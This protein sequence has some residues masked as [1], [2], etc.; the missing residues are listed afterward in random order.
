M[1]DLTFDSSFSN[2]TVYI[3]DGLTSS[4]LQTARHLSE[5]LSDLKYEIETPYCSIIRTDSRSSFFTA[6]SEIKSLC[7][8]GIRP[9]IHIECHG[10][11]NSGITIGDKKEK[12]AWDEL[13][14]S[15][16]EV[17]KATK[18]NLGI[19]MAGCFGLHAIKP[20]TITKPSP[21][22]FLIGSEGEISAGE[23]DEAMKSFYRA[24]FQ[25]DS[26]QTAMG[27]ID[28]RFKQFHAE[29][30]F[31]ISFGRYIKQKCIGK[32]RNARVENL[33]SELFENGI[34]RNR[35]SLRRYR[36]ELKQLT[37][38]NK[39]A[40]QKFADIFMHGRYAITYEQLHTFV[41]QKNNPT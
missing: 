38:P 17:N 23:I 35:E 22:Y 7:I 13:V 34:P 2:N 3:L 20:I 39:A 19:V 15:F 9:I 26:L 8:D 5:G 6:L 32:G 1:N 21:F 28:K 10:D 24:L 33:L 29:K 27:Q 16:R 36:K 41:T 40:F 11:M 25:S 14:D 30:M 31:C 12:I 37:R 4:E 18:N